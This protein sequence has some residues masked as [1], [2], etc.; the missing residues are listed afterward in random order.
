MVSE[1]LHQFD[2][3]CSFYQRN[4]AVLLAFFKYDIAGGIH[5]SKAIRTGI[6]KP[7]K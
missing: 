4:S 2:K 5:L 7:D 3:S 1:T 6:R